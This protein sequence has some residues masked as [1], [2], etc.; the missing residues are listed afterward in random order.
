MSNGGLLDS[1]DLKEIG[2]PF[3]F[4]STMSNSYIRHLLYTMDDLNEEELLKLEEDIVVSWIDREFDKLVGLKNIKKRSRRTFKLNY[5]DTTWGRLIRSDDIRDPTSYNARL[6]KRRFRVPFGLFEDII[7]P[8]CEE[9][10]IFETTYPTRIRV[11][12]EF[13]VLMCLRI[14]G[15]GN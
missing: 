10:N 11:P 5:W 3:F 13:K 7:V 1:I 4:K 6:F 9:K 15:Q 14:L 2:T 12:V 8:M